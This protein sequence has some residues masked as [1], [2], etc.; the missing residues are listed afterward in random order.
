[1]T[2]LTVNNQVFTK[3]FDWLD[4]AGLGTGA[5]MVARAHRRGAERLIEG[6][7]LAGGA[8]A[9]LFQR[10]PAL[11]EA[12]SVRAHTASPKR[13][14]WLDRTVHRL[15]YP[16]DWEL[17]RYLANSTDCAD[18]EFRMRTWARRRNGF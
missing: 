17:E 3:K 13:I 18:L 11:A 10:R 16:A 1:M 7:A 4:H 12:D 9:S 14:G 8:L 15:M 2:A 6:L 5:L